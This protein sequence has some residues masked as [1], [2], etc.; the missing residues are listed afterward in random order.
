MIKVKLAG[1]FAV[2][3]EF[4]RQGFP[5]NA[6]ARLFVVALRLTKLVGIVVVMK[7]VNV[8]FL[9]HKRAGIPTVIEDVAVFGGRSFLPNL[10]ILPPRP[11]W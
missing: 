7:V 3:R 1:P 4:L 5:C 11:V 8:A 10:K 2:F 6:Q 9:N